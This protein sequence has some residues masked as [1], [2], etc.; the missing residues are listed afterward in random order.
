MAAN[1]SYRVVSKCSGVGSCGELFGVG[2]GRKKACKRPDGSLPSFSCERSDCNRIIQSIVVILLCM[3]YPLHGTERP[4]RQRFTYN[5]KAVRRQSVISPVIWSHSPKSPG[6]RICP[7]DTSA[8]PRMSPMTSEAKRS[9][10][11]PATTAMAW[12]GTRWPSSL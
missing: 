12:G 7:V 6:Y 2:M 11:A 9:A 5:R 3:L 4:D 8:V 1:S 10:R